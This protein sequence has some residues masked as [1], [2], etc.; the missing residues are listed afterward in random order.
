[1]TQSSCKHDTKSK[2]RPGMKRAS[3]Q[4]FSCKH[5]LRLFPIILTTHVLLS[6]VFG[7]LHLARSISV[8]NSEIK[9]KT[10]L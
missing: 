6:S 1:M 5:L 7:F 10:S 3:V 2:S 9:E 4:G 8:N